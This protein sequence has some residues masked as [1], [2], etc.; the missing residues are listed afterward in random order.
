MRRIFFT[1]I[2]FVLV[3]GNIVTGQTNTL[4][5]IAISK[6]DMAKAGESIPASE[7]GEPVGSVKLY[8]ARWVEATETSP[9][10]GVVKDRFFRLTPMDGQ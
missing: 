10:Y 6:A 9:A 5:A 2:A 1:I 8:E 4:S 3:A 7:I